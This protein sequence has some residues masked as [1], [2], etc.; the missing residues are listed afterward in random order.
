MV[1]A[2]REGNASLAVPVGGTEVV[3]SLGG[4]GLAAG[5][6]DRR[7]LVDPQ[8]DMLDRWGSGVCLSKSSLEH[9]E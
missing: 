1:P 2:R 4:Q 3:T 8:V 6:L 7:A 5:V 9:P